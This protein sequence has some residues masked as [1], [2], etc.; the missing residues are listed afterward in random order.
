MKEMKAKHC[1]L[2]IFPLV[3]RD[4][5]VIC[6]LSTFSICMKLL[7]AVLCT[8]IVCLSES[9][10]PGWCLMLLLMAR[11]TTL[12]GVYVSNDSEF[13]SQEALV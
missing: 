11:K 2:P 4:S 8:P 10:P 1:D 12:D 6:A 5:T 3:A 9:S 7:L 13:L